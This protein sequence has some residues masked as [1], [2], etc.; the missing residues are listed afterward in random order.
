MHIDKKRNTADLAA[1]QA[2]LELVD[3]VELLRTAAGPERAVQRLEHR[4]EEQE[5]TLVRI[6][7]AAAFA[8]FV[9]TLASVY[10][11][12]GWQ[13]IWYLLVSIMLLW[14]WHYSS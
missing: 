4:W 10:P 14:C 13:P 2:T 1:S 3:H 7:R 11:L 6:N 12:Q 5:E 9:A 8:S